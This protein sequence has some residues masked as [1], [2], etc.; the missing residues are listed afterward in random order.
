VWGGVWVWGCGCGPRDQR[1]AQAKIWF[2]L[3]QLES[4]LGRHSDAIQSFSESI[5]KD[6][7]S[8]IVGGTLSQS[9]MSRTCTS[10]A[11]ATDTLDAHAYVTRTRT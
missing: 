5:A 3:G 8:A 9:P 11:R 7:Y 2:N 6:A 4:E 1:S 10:H